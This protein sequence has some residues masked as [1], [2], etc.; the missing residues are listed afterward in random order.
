MF[1]HIKGI[2][3]LYLFDFKEMSN[4]NISHLRKVIIMS[5]LLTGC[6]SIVKDFFIFE[7]EY[8]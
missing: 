5:L 8:D 7:I 4:D 1:E 2:F 3:F 6:R